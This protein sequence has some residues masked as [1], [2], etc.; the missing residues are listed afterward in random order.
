MV[1]H[2]QVKCPKTSGSQINAE[3]NK[4]GGMQYGE[5]KNYFLC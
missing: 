3:R 1:S 4:S 5:A 2:E